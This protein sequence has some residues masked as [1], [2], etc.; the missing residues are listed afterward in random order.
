M[1]QNGFDFI[2]ALKVG[3]S[4]V[5]YNFVVKLIL[6]DNNVCHFKKDKVLFDWCMVKELNAGKRNLA[7]ASIRSCQ[8]QLIM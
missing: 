4:E 6:G 7:D 2:L 8:K 5:V 3:K 1:P